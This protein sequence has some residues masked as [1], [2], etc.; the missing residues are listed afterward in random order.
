MGSADGNEDQEADL[1]SAGGVITANGVAAPKRL[2]QAAATPL[3]AVGDDAEHATQ[4]MAASLAAMLSN[5]LTFGAPG[6]ASWPTQPV[7]QEPAQQGD[8]GSCSALRD[9]GTP[10]AALPAAALT[11]EG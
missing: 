8:S 1:P 3:A 6:T 11:A 10:T 2:S 4:Q 5:A 7:L 9:G